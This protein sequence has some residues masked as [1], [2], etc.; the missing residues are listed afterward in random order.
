MP[1][2][3]EVGLGKRVSDLARGL[4][5][6]RLIHVKTRIDIYDRGPDDTA[7]KIGEQPDLDLL[8]HPGTGVRRLRSEVED[9]DHFDALAKRATLLESPIMAHPKQVAPLLDDASKVVWILGGSRAGKTDCLSAKGKRSL[10]RIG[11]PE[12]LLW[13][14]APS[15]TQAQIGVKKLFREQASRPALFPRELVRSYPTKPKTGANSAHFF[16]GS[17]LDFHHANGDGDNL[18]GENVCAVLCD[19]FTAINRIENYRISM[20][21]TLDNDGQWIGSSTPKQGH[22][23]YDEIL[24]GQETE[25]AAVY[26]FTC[27]DNPWMPRHA[28]DRLIKQMGGPE[29]PIVRREVFGEWISDGVLAFEDF[30]PDRHTF[31]G[32]GRHAENFGWKNITPQVA[33]A[34]WR[35]QGADWTYVGGQD[36]NVDPMGSCIAQIAVRPGED[37]GNPD[38]W[39]LL[40]LDE[41]ATI[42]RLE[43]HLENL[44]GRYP[45]IPF[46]VDPTGAREGT[47][48]SQANYTK[49]A[50]TNMLIMRGYG[51]A[52]AS[53]H[54]HDGKVANVGV[55]DSLTLCNRLLREG[56]IRIH[57]RCKRLIHGLQVLPSN[58]VGGIAKKPG[59]E[60]DKA[61]SIPDAL[62]YLAWKIFHRHVLV[63]APR[64]DVWL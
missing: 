25:D 62:R 55:P 4:N 32:D 41:M 43:K 36:F 54:Y 9:L 59:T 48:A 52:A 57:R 45:G 44:K 18:R 20:N 22:W 46:A 21:R 56:R 33:P 53:A 42:G 10:I 12:A 19:E 51:F 26:S 34:Y 8:L 49:G 58:A 40:V 5:S 27:F 61:S 64:G 17:R 63:A 60:M 38:N 30:E 28:I 3:E 31:V 39:H 7:V 2:R 37:E 50:T 24:R 15:W 35:D 6:N 23:A 11:G 29:D 1:S 13:W 14:L 47:H 16:D